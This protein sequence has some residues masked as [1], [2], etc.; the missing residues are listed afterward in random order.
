MDYYITIDIGVNFAGKHYSIEK[1]KRILSECNNYVTH[2]ISISNSLKEVDINESL[3][4]Y[5]PNI[6]YTV[7]VHPHNAKNIRNL[8][9][10]HILTKKSQNSFCVAIGECGLDYN[11]MFSTKEK[12][13]AVFKK[14]IEIA[15]IVKKPLY[16][17]CRDAFDDFYQILKDSDY[18]NGVI[19]CFTGNKDQS[20][21]LEQLGF[22]FGI[23]GWLLDNRRNKDLVEAVKSISIDK[24]LV[25][26]DA[27]WLSIYRTHESHPYDTGAIVQ[28]IARIK[29]MGV[30]EC[31]NI[32]YNN[33]K[34]LFEFCKNKNIY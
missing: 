4:N 1:I 32:I 20:Y 23:T 8:D 10:L 28:E 21:K 7:G 26:T 29:E 12:Q 5:F 34:K 19:H 30:N 17:H 33:S 2:L 3:P 16:L 13:I 11:R 9:D 25:E 31:G 27:P 24:L 15:K 6:Y 14:Q 22:Y 18:Y